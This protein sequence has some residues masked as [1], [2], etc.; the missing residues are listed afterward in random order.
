M[1]YLS[2]KL[3]RTKT[4]WNKNLSRKVMWS[5]CCTSII[6]LDWKPEHVHKVMCQSGRIWGSGEFALFDRHKFHLVVHLQNSLCLELSS[7]LS[8]KSARARS[9]KSQA[10]FRARRYFPIHINRNKNS[11]AQKSRSN[12]K[13]LSWVRESRN[14]YPNPLPIMHHHMHVSERGPCYRRII[15]TKTKP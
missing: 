13:R 2:C 12:Q 3:L 10:H 4:L 11:A 14:L 7:E 5:L 1:L 9:I 6:F 15:G 8:H